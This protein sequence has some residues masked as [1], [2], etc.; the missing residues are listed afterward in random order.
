MKK[1]HKKA[2]HRGHRFS[3]WVI[4][5]RPWSFPASAMP[6]IVT[7][8]YLFWKGAAINW[9]YG[10]WALVGMMLF[11]MTGNT[12][13]DYFDFKK[14]VDANDTFGAKTITTGMFE[15]REI[16]NLAIGLLIISVACGLG[17]FAVTGLPLLWIGLAGMVLTLLYPLMKF[18]ALGDLDILLTFAFLPTLG[19]SYA[20][21]GVID[22]S[23]LYVALPVGLITDGILH[24][25]NTRDTHTDKRAGIK[26]M[27]MALGAKASAIL[28]GFEVLF[29]FVWV[30]VLSILGIF[31]LTT[32]IIFL[33]LAVAIG[34]S[35]TMMKSLNGDLRIIA[36][37][38]VRTANLQLMFSLLLTVAFVVAKFI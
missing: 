13:S 29:P 7:L 4:A 25:N 36:D 20:A 30:G 9:L 24:S 28:Y 21:T 17:L 15:A 1:K 5:V 26:T 33:T 35:Q 11:H 22:W 32:I 12:W 14:K 2:A 10:A 18:N 34:C 8:A 37:L 6:I 38:D 27:A 23:V 19:A 31:P 16:R 3:D